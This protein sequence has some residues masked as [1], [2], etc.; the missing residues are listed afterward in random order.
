[1]QINDES[2]QKLITIV[3]PLHNR[4]GNINTLL[5]YYNDFFFNII[6]ADSSREPVYIDKKYI[7]KKNI[8]YTYIKDEFYYLKMYR[9][10]SSI[11]TPYCLELPDDDFALPKKIVELID[12]LEKHKGYVSAFGR[13]LVFHR[14]GEIDDN[15][16]RNQ[17]M[18]FEN[19]SW[20]NDNAVQKMQY[21]VDHFIPPNHSVN[22]T[23]A[24]LLPFKFV[25]EYKH[26]YPVRFFDKIFFVILSAIGKIKMLKGLYQ[27]RSGYNR[28]IEQDKELS[29]IHPLLEIDVHFPQNFITRLEKYNENPFLEFFEKNRCNTILERDIIVKMLRYF[30][31]KQRVVY[32]ESDDFVKRLD[33]DARLEV[34][35]ILKIVLQRSDVHWLS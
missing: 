20:T 19:N 12:F 35:K 11:K 16:N 28:T 17:Y 30:P 3:I 8:S 25:L 13:A 9:V 21:Q 22:R 34:A 7:N 6:V 2:L 27:L 23:V 24:A 29:L 5:K 15:Y 31:I 14:N 4:S 32:D 1:M 18:G 33:D 10:L 26:F